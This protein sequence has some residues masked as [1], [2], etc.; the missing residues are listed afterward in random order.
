MTPPDPSFDY[1]HPDLFVA[2]ALGEPGSRVFH[3]QAAQDHELI[4]IKCEKQHVAALATHLGRIL[5]DLPPA[6]SSEVAAI[7]SGLRQPVEDL[8]TAGNLGVAYDAAN[9]RIV[10]AIERFEDSLAAEDD[11]FDDEGV[12]RPLDPTGRVALSRAQAAAFVAV[13]TALVESGRPSCRFCGGPIDA[14]GH[15]CPR[16]NGF[17]PRR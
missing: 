3:L 15:A 8:W 7:E 16:A 13:A 4:S 9:D 1:D 5:A 11:D 2:G 6:D 10:V 12:S 17:R 14:A